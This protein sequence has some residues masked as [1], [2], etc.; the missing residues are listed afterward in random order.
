MAEMFNIENADIGKL[1]KKKRWNTVGLI[2]ISICLTVSLVIVGM[3]VALEI[4][5]S[6]VRNDMHIDPEYAMYIA[7]DAVVSRRYD[8]EECD[9]LRFYDS[10]SV[11]RTLFVNAVPKVTVVNDNGYYVEIL[12]NNALQDAMAVNVSENILTID[13]RDDL[14]NRVHEDDVDYDYDYGMYVD[15]TQLEITVHAPIN[16]FRTGTNLEVDLQMA[17]ADY[18]WLQFFDEGVQGVVSG[19][20]TQIF[21]LDCVGS[22]RLVL[23]GTVHDTARIML[24]HDTRIDARELTAN[25]WD[26][27]ISRSIG[28]F[29]YLIGRKWPLIDCATIGDPANIIAC[30]VYIPFVFWVAMEISQIIKRRKLSRALA[31]QT[32]M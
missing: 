12:T 26:T 3:F 27:Q 5:C 22:S 20:D 21:D 2:V 15:C 14:Y 19:I 6:G 18:T 29:S 30:I 16:T 8:I 31:Q 10:L 4:A 7:D 28:G 13:C 23:K 1:L 25:N 32:Q 9:T 17:K 11:R 24:W